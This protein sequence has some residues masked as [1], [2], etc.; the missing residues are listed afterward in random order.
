MALQRA[1]KDTTDDRTEILSVLS[2]EKVDSDFIPRS[3]NPPSDDAP[4]MVVDAD[5]EVAK[6]VLPPFAL[7][8]ITAMPPSDG[9]W[10]FGAAGCC[11]SQDNGDATSPRPSLLPA[12]T[13]HSVQAPCKRVAAPAPAVAHRITPSSASGALAHSPALPSRRIAVTPVAPTGGPP[14]ITSVLP[15]QPVHPVVHRAIA[16]TLRTQQGIELPARPIVGRRPMVAAPTAIGTAQPIPAAAFTG[17]AVMG[18]GASTMIP[19]ACAPGKVGTVVRQA[20]PA[21]VS[22]QRV[23]C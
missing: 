19:V 10:G 22:M 16:P 3:V 6:S 8:K 18:K 17:A 13:V 1:R 12:P 9:F 7:Q 2:S 14:Q 20:T 21:A 4:M 5:E 11:S 23:P 15:Q